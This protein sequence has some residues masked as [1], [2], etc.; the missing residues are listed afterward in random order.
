M[1]DAE[2]A[3]RTP[4]ITTMMRMPLAGI[5]IA[6]AV[7]LV[8]AEGVDDTIPMAFYADPELSK[9]TSLYQFVALAAAPYGIQ[10]DSQEFAQDLGTKKV[11][12]QQDMAADN[13]G[14]AVYR[15]Y[16]DGRD[17]MKTDYARRK[18]D[19][20]Y[21]TDGLPN[22]KPALD[23][24]RALRAE[25]Y[26]ACRKFMCGF[27]ENCSH[28][29][30]ANCPV[31]RKVLIKKAS[32]ITQGTAKGAVSLLHTQRMPDVRNPD[33]QL[34]K[35]F[36]KK[37]GS[38]K[39]FAYST[40]GKLTNLAYLKCYRIFTHIDKQFLRIYGKLEKAKKLK[41]EAKDMKNS[42]IAQAFRKTGLSKSPHFKKRA[43]SSLY[44][45]QDELYQEALAPPTLYNQEVQQFDD[46]LE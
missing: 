8:A 41:Q 33:P 35:Q 4:R 26:G 38:G 14:E 42:A 34:R 17:E 45:Q 22:T 5:A 19:T 23:K 39:T 7:A 29:I 12:E 16:L 36:S 21:K 2:G 6:V 10:I 43:F 27:H 37:C 13:N 3:K 30:P 40:C 1:G 20:H 18:Q 9:V 25:T 15:H 28:K 32:G 31:G 11:S 24:C 44:D 46:D